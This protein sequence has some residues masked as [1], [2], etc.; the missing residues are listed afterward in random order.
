MAWEWSHS[1]EAY[2]KAYAD[3]HKMGVCKLAVI[4]AEWH[5]ELNE[6]A[7]V[8]ARYVEARREARRLMR[9]GKDI[10][11]DMIWE[12]ACEARTCDNGG[13]HLWMC[14]HGCGCHCV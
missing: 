10:V 3:L 13:H 2:D 6:E 7:W 12:W 14:P 4:Y 1:Q 9:H 8:E 11:A 5:M